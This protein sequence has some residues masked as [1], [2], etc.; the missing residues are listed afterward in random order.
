MSSWCSYCSRVL[1]LGEVCPNHPAMLV[2]E[3]HEES[4]AP[5]SSY[6]ISLQLTDAA[7]RVAALED[8]LKLVQSC[9]YQA[10]NALADWQNV[11]GNRSA[12]VNEARAH[13]T[14]A[15]ETL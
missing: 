13:L 4:A 8:K 5:D 3:T 1:G 7:K 14:K 15:L 2:W 6:P 9:V 11:T 12:C 10:D